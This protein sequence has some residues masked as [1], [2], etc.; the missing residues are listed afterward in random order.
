MKKMSNT[1]ITSIK[2]SLETKQQHKKIRNRTFTIIFLTTLLNP[3]N[4]APGPGKWPLIDLK[5]HA[6]GEK[7]TGLCSRATQNG[8]TPSTA[9]NIKDPNH[10][11]QYK[12]LW[13]AWVKLPVG[14]IMKRY[15][16]DPNLQNTDESNEYS[17]LK[18]GSG[19]DIFFQYKNSHIFVLN[20]LTKF[21]E[22]T[23]LRTC[24]NFD[25]TN[26]GVCN[27]AKACASNVVCRERCP[28]TQNIFSGVCN[29]DHTKRC[30]TVGTEAWF[31]IGA[32]YSIMEPSGGETCKLEFSN[33]RASPT[34]SDSSYGTTDCSDFSDPL[35]LHEAF[36]TNRGG[37]NS[38]IT[39]DSGE[40]KLQLGY[41]TIIV[42][43]RAS[44]FIVLDKNELYVTGRGNTGSDLEITLDDI[45]DYHFNLNFFI[46]LLAGEPTPF[47]F[48]DFTRWNPL[49]MK[50]Y[51]I[52]YKFGSAEMKK[53][54]FENYSPYGFPIHP[55][56]DLVPNS[57]PFTGGLE[58]YERLLELSGMPLIDFDN[59]KFCA[60]FSSTLTVVRKAANT[61]ASD[62]SNRIIFRIRFGFK[63]DG[64]PGGHTY[65]NN[66]FVIIKR[67][68]ASHI[69]AYISQSDDDSIPGTEAITS[70]GTDFKVDGQLKGDLTY[71]TSWSD[72]GFLEI[73]AQ[74]TLCPVDPEKE[75][76]QQYIPIIAS[77]TVKDSE[78]QIE[79]VSSKPIYS[80]IGQATKQAFNSKLQTMGIRISVHDTL[81]VKNNLG[82]YVSNLCV[83]HGGF[84]PTMLDRATT[85]T[86]TYP[87]YNFWKNH[88][89]EKSPFAMIG[90]SRTKQDGTK[91]P[92]DSVYLVRCGTEDPKMFLSGDQKSCLIAEEIPGCLRYRADTDN[93]TKGVCERCEENSL[94]WLDKSNP[95]GVC[96]LK[97]ENPGFEVN[98]DSSKQNHYKEGECH[99]CE[100]VEDG[101][102]CN[103]NQVA[104]DIVGTCKCQPD[105][106]KFFYFL[107]ISRRS[108]P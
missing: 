74:F 8:I 6:E 14:M 32:D 103:S 7:I 47:K 60:S 59:L 2:N 102:I 61:L 65:A 92:N 26:P 76:S 4:S 72:Q 80:Y 70:S 51:L 86:V 46:A 75:N 45:R 19:R 35:R 97:V 9:S 39:Q 89:L 18:Y 84:S 38:D 17:D 100:A 63:Q 94:Y 105:G 78:S 16:Y 44:A 23:F 25:E 99:T 31:F 91:D 3:G 57:S 101:C 20:D 54:L 93:P 33:L 77:L 85:D 87:D 50:D 40:I 37:P 67:I 81:S 43:K 28:R 73:L 10:K 13:T 107:I 88:F 22:K 62:G 96:K 71:P 58:F 36:A 90:G 1:K 48:F 49:M 11:Y 79:K 95:E 52:A 66:L 24:Y 41:E 42:K 68:D 106:C 34:S 15:D 82:F 12:F 64:S 27:S 69:K 5:Y 108:L 30:K 104:G 29:Q 83:Y 56:M 53:F 21:N 98:C 55:D